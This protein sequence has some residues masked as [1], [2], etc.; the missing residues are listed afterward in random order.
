MW[1]EALPQTYLALGYMATLL[2]LASHHVLRTLGCRLKAIQNVVELIIQCAHNA[3]WY[4][5]IPACRQTFY[6]NLKA[7]D[8][9]LLVCD[10][11]AMR[12]ASW[13]MPWLKTLP[14]EAK[15]LHII[16]NKCNT[17]ALATEG[18]SEALVKQQVC[19]AIRRHSSKTSF[20]ESQV[21]SFH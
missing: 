16:V 4:G 14:E 20:S 2:L 3:Y 1:S 18:D 6:D 17:L 7:F 21:R 19:S 13:N 9:V 12:K 10:Y 8:A 15:K 11:D 5:Y